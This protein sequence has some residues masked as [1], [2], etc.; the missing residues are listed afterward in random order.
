MADDTD[1]EW[2]RHPKTGKGATWNIITGCQIVSPGCTNCYAMKLAGTRLKHH[3]S[4]EGLTTPGAK[5]PVWTG[6]IRFNTQWL[7]QPLG[8]KVPRGIFVCAHGDLFA[9][10]VTDAML[11][12]IFAVMALRPDHVFYV[13]TKRP[14]RMREYLLAGAEV[15]ID[16]QTRPGERIATAAYAIADASSRA[17]VKIYQGLRDRCESGEDILPLTNV[18]LG[19]SVED[20]PRADARVSAMLELSKAGWNTW[21]SYEPAIGPVDWKEW[22]FL[23]WLVSGGESGPRP[24]HPDWHRS[25]RDFC[26]AIGV[27]YFFKQWGSWKPIL[28]RDVEDPDWRAEYSRFSDRGDRVLNLA[29]GFGFH[30]DRVHIMSKVGKKAAGRTLDG[31]EHNAFPE[32]NP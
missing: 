18:M 16:D 22:K 25:T 11:D 26:T 20:Q 23:D 30:G 1:I 32:I 10:G 15:P 31:I 29:G 27:P 17:N 13:L 3:P 6:E 9:D 4:R 19:C 12:Q 21:V 24:T 8:W 5:G 2:A 14:E 28:D 7:D